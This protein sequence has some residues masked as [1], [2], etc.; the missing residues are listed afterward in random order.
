MDEKINNQPNKPINN[1]QTLTDEIDEIHFNT[2]D[3]SH[4]IALRKYLYKNND[5]SIPQKK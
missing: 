1:M 4:K 5:G 3:R 2:R